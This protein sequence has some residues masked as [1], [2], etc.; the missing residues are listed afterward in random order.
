MVMPRFLSGRELEQVDLGPLLSKRVRIQGTT[1][2][3]C[4][5]SYQADLVERFARD[6][7]C[8]LTGTAS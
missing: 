8:K 5:V 1:L 3:T 4:S 2:R 6:V 7:I